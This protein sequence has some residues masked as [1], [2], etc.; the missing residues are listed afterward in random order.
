MQSDPTSCPQIKRE[1][2]KYINWQQL[3]KGTRSKPHEQ[4]FSRR[5]SVVLHYKCNITNITHIVIYIIGLCYRNWPCFIR[6][7]FL[8]I[9]VSTAN[10]NLS[11]CVK[12]RS[13]GIIPITTRLWRHRRAFIPLKPG[14]DFIAGLQHHYS[15]L[16]LKRCYSV[17]QRMDVTYERSLLS[18]NFQMSGF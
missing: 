4:L 11:L 6:H 17:Q 1:I 8:S 9:S 14:Y 13:Q 7:N 15:P 16:W 2:T 10:S 5:G 3:T 18:P 12:N